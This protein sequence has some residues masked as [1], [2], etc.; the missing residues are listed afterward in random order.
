MVVKTNFK[1]DIR[2]LAKLISGI[3]SR[4][5]S[6]LQELSDLVNDMGPS[7]GN[8]RVIGITGPPGAGKSTIVDG[9]IKILR[10]NGAKVGV[11]AIDPSSPFSGGAI[12]GDR[13]RMQE[14]ASDKGVFIR[15][16][17]SRGSHGGL[18]RATRDI[19]RAISAFRFDYVIVETVGVGQTELDIMEI[20]DATIV[21]LVP[22]SGDMIQTMKAGLLE[23]ADIF[24]V[25]KADRAGAEQMQSF[26]K[27]MF[28]GG[29][30]FDAEAIKHHGMDAVKGKRAGDGTPIREIPVLL[31]EANKGVGLAELMDVVKEKFEF[32]KTDSVIKA[33]KQK[34]RLQEFLE[35][36]TE[37]FK[38][39][40]AEAM[41]RDKKLK[42]LAA[43]IETGK[44]N[45]Y[46]ALKVID[47]LVRFGK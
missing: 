4:E 30:G 21:V 42:I 46:E 10:Q 13:I 7:G 2:K 29:A 47:K 24:V 31:A 25:N 15:S 33:R 35:I 12:L 34:L 22:E 32:I 39:R 18:S 43:E 28:D 16:V 5:K 23:I 19:V 20:A 1:M 36:C 41:E 11:V 8:V 14:H 45:S 6:A 37:E 27:G 9:M 38:A 44:K 26:L 17:G 40:L 3:E